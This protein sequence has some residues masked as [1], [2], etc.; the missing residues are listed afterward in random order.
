MRGHLPHLG[1]AE[2]EIHR[3]RFEAK[4]LKFVGSWRNCRPR[5][6]SEWK[7]GCSATPS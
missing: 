7:F 5:D 6:M 2:C 3:G 1:A 4:W